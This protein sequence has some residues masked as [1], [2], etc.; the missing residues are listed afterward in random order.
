MRE[1]REQLQE[2]KRKVYE[3]NAKLDDLCKGNQSVMEQ[4]TFSCSSEGILHFL[5]DKWRIR[6]EW[7]R[8][9]AE[10]QVFKEDQ[11][12]VMDT[13]EKQKEALDKAKTTFMREQ[14]DLVVR[15]STERASLEQEK[16]D[17]FT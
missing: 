17:F 7:A 1:E 15:V 13:L 14:H 9:N 5:Q 2:E 4:V 6:D 10:K 8:L 16:N 3:L 12:Y 11:K